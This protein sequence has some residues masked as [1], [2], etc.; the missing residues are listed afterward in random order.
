[1]SVFTPVSAA[2]MA[3]RLK[4]YSIGSL[5][6]L[7]GILAGIENTNYFLTTSHGRY[8]LTLFEKLQMHE[9]P[10][11]INLM[12]HLA[13]HGI[14]CPAP[15]ADVRD[16]YL[17]ELNDRPSCIVTCLK[18]EAV[19]APEATHCAQIGEILAEMHIAGQTYDGRM[20][21]QRGPEWW[22]AT[23]PEVYPFMSADAVHVLR[24]E[25]RFQER[26]RFDKLPEGAI[27]A[28]LFRDNVLFDGDKIGG[29]IDFYFACNDLLLYDVA[30]TI[31]DWC[32]MDDGDID[33]VKARSMLTAYNAVRPFRVEEAAN[34]GV[35]LRAAALRFWVSRLYDF[36]K[37]RPS[38][39]NK[40]KDP[41]HFERVLK[42]HI[43]RDP[44]K[45]WL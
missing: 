35:M 20:P 31:N 8:V 38:E 3:E 15:I 41:A 27:H 33:P 32:V 23:A 24:D 45:L 21:N 19:M 16:E 22:T 7:K 13:R 44:S 43:A 30:I 10:F 11:Y 2:Q 39:L 29:V 34:W 26:H 40:P 14:A 12:A 25:V 5:V 42:K 37:P 28:D 17:A 4:N 6:E 1:M 36:H 18:G 9:L